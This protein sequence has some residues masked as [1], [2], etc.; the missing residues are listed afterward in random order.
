[1]VYAAR[2]RHIAPGVTFGIAQ[3]DE[4]EADDLL[5]LFDYALQMDSNALKVAQECRAD[6]R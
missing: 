5:D 6:V 4:K 2:R 3:R 1:M